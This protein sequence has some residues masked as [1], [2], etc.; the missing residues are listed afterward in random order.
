[1]NRTLDLKLFVDPKTGSLA[2]TVKHTET[3]SLEDLTEKHAVSSTDR[4]ESESA[5]KQAAATSVAEFLGRLRADAEDKVTP[6]EK[7]AR[8]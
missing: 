5:L 1:M 4:W 2:M 3:N 6:I 8:G 7:A